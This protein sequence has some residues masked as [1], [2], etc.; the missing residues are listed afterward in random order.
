M[1]WRTNEISGFLE[2]RTNWNG[3]DVGSNG[4]CIHSQSE[5]LLLLI[6]MFCTSCRF[7]VL[8]KN[9][10]YLLKNINVSNK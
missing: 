3:L 4:F 6:E 10:G 2:L 1:L 9:D 7:V 8:R 5:K